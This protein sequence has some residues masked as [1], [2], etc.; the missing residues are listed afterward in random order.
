MRY[1]KTSYSCGAAA[2][3]NALRSLGARVAEKSAAR[4]AST[5][6]EIGTTESGIIDALREMGYIVTR[7]ETAK[8]REAWGYL[9]DNLEIGRPVILCV[10][11]WQH[12]V[13]AIGKLND[14]IVL[15]DPT[16]TRVNKSENGVWVLSK[17]EFMKKWRHSQKDL[18]SGIS[19][20]KK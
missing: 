9:N 10:M 20:G 18:Y 3:V 5:T 14:R 19:V 13:T 7:L 1:Q 2:I 17:R 12:W 6:L 8:S 4:A 16:N 15:V 11:N